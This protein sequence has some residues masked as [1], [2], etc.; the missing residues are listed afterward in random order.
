MANTLNFVEND[1]LPEL[2]STYTGVNIT[3]YDI[4]LHIK[5][6]P[7]ALT[8]SAVITSA[9]NGAFKFTFDSKVVTSV[10]EAAEAGDTTVKVPSAD[11]ADLPASGE[12]VI[13]EDEVREVRRYTS[14]TAPNI[15]NLEDELENDHEAG[16]VLT[17]LPDLRAGKWEAEVQVTDASGKART[18][19]NLILDIAAEIA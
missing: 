9:A 2:T 6:K 10:D 7:N 15:L 8:K 16:E 12:V 3:G 14:K 19:R 17:K 4:E 5:Y 1:N 11:Y 18:F 13:G